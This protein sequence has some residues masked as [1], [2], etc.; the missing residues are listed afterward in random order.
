MARRR[1]ATK[2]EILAD[3]KYGSKELAK[4]IN[5]IMVDGKKSTAER[6]VYGAL[7]LLEQRNQKLGAVKGEKSGD[8]DGGSDG[9]SAGGAG[10]LS[11]LVLFLKALRN[12][13]PLVEVRSKRVGGSTYQ[14]PIEVPAVR[15][16]TLGMRWLIVIAKKRG[17]KTMALRLCNE[18]LD[19]AQ[20]RGATVKKRV[21]M[22]RM[23]DANK[24]F[25]HFRW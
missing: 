4:F 18:L 6:I 8:D 9:G 24:A 7:E 11:G 22:H 1:V 21:D 14:I 17:E 25:A 15:R 13:G 20:N 5:C 23:A 10:G 19:A 16:N 2:R 12:V 3:P